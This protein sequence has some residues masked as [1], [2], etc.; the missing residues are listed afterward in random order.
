MTNDQSLPREPVELTP[1]IKAAGDRMADAIYG[2]WT[3]NCPVW[4]D[5]EEWERLTGPIS[6][7]ENTE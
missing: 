7:A 5:A 2:E 6:W 1:E 3:P 4:K